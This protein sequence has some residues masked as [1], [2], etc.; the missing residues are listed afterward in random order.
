MKS[1]AIKIKVVCYLTLN[2]HHR[3]N[4]RVRGVAW[5]DVLSNESMYFCPGPGTMITF[6][7]RHEENILSSHQSVFLI[8]P[9]M[10]P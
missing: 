2:F 9:V 4:I 7:V 8:V 5:E 1:I 10:I 3:K 6:L